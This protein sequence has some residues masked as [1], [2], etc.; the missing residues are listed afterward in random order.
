[1]E[2]INEK[3]TTVCVT[4]GTEGANFLRKLPNA[5]QKLKIFRTNSENLESFL[6]AI[7]GCNGVIIRHSVDFED[8]NDD[9]TKIQRAITAILGVLKACF[10]S[11]TIKRVIY[12]SSDGA[13][14]YV[15][16]GQDVIVDENS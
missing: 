14:G 11:K 10:D 4:G 3:G 8:E 1:M 9:N 15:T 5:S 13:I 12:T 16:E 7:E 2:N 6:P